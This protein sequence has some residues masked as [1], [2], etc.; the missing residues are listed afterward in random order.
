MKK[1]RQQKLAIV[2]KSITRT[3]KRAKKKKVKKR[4]KERGRKGKRELKKEGS[5]H[6][7]TRDACNDKSFN[8]F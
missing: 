6:Y 8:E 2:I 4:R 5:P 3:E 7:N 1:K